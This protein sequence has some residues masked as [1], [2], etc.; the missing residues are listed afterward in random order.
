MVV[1]VDGVR[2]RRMDVISGT[3]VIAVM[4]A[5]IDDT[6]A[7][8]IR[9]DLLRVLNSGVHSGVDALIIDM[10][11]TTFCAVAGVHTLQRAHQRARVTRTDLRLVATARAVLKVLTLGGIHRIIAIHPSLQTASTAATAPPQRTP[12]RTGTRPLEP[13]R[14]PATHER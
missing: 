11:A 7:D 1:T 5:E 9:E 12:A 13:L 3:G 6:N 2:L 8:R 4:P 10:S 14:P